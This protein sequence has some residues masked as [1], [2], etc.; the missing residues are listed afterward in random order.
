MQRTIARAVEFTGTGLHT[1]ETGRVVLKPGAPGS[2]VWGRAGV[3]VTSDG[4]VVFE[5]GDGPYD[6]SKNLYSDSVIALAGKDLKLADYFFM[7]RRRKLVRFVRHDWRRQKI[8]GWRR[9]GCLPFE[10]RQIP[11]IR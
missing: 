6:P 8:L 4:R 11:R 3:A 5:T 10:P 7:L 9:R 1:G 2:G